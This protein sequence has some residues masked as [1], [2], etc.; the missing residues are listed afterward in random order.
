VA[1]L[2]GGGRM[3]KDFETGI[4]GMRGDERKQIDVPYPAD[5]HNAALAAGSRSSTCT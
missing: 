1:V 3:L 5:Y 2:L 4:T